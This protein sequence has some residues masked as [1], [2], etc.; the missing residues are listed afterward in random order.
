MSIST[1][2]WKVWTTSSQPNKDEVSKY[3]PFA[4][5][6]VENISTRSVVVVA[7]GT[8][9]VGKSTFLSFLAGEKGLFE[10]SSGMSVVTKKIQ[11]ERI[12]LPCSLTKLG[13]DQPRKLPHD[14][15][16]LTLVDLPGLEECTD[17][18]PETGRP[19]PPGYSSTKRPQCTKQY[20]S[21]LE[22]VFTESDGVIHAFLLV[23]DSSD[24]DYM[25]PEL[26]RIQEALEILRIDYD[27]V[28]IIFT[29]GG[30]WGEN[31]E[32]R[33]KEFK[34]KMEEE[35]SESSY[36]HE[37]V[38][39]VNNRYLMQIIRQ[40]IYFQMTLYDVVDRSRST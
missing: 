4:G 22:D 7:L 34:L 11:K 16:D 18:D 31:H 2:P 21:L 32:E 19:S 39:S 38:T 14:L 12:K 8:P 29:H 36:T 30:E 13:F 40:V 3:P 10:A 33:Q 27:N 1:K 28:I 24:L 25:I 6:D 17:L 5:F 15:N 9:G 23:I 35:E 37:L 26:E 20:A